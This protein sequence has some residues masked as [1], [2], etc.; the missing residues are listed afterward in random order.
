[1]MTLPINLVLVRHGDSEGNEAKRRS[2]QGDHSLHEK[3]KDRHTRS[4]RLSPKGRAQ[5]QPTGLWLRENFPHGFDRFLVSEYIRAKETAGLLELP[6]ARWC[7]DPYMSERDWG[8]LDQ[9]NED[10]RREKYARELQMRNIEPF[11]WRPGGG[12][13]FLTLC[14][15]A[16]RVLDTQ[17]RSNPDESVI[18]VNHGEMKMA[19]RMRIERFSYDRFCEL[20][21]SE[22]PEDRIFNCEI[23]HYTRCDPHT[24][25]MT[26]Y[27]SW[28]RRIRPTENPVWTT[29]WQKIERVTYSNE[30]LLAEVARY[31]AELS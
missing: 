23:T 18:A 17:H 13:T 27:V 15:R 5:T 28:M 22:K 14:L 12:E 29:G 8:D 9:Y 2:K 1:M 7:S 21:L 10:E 31:K 4:Y 30:D 6:N 16:D 24:G 3:L 19:L 25:E 26:P 11:F 20:H